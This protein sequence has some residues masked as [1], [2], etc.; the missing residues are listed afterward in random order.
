MFSKETD[1]SAFFNLKVCL[2]PGDLVGF[3]EGTFGTSGQSACPPRAVRW[4]TL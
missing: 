3:I 2:E 1:I 4:S